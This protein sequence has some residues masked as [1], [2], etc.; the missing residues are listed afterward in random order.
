MKKA[1]RIVLKAILWIIGSVVGLILLVFILIR[2]PAIQNFVV[3]KVT[4]Y[5][6]N[7]IKTPVRI[8]R[9]TLDLP[10]MLVLEGVY[11][12]DQQRDTLLAGDKLK[13][14]ISMLKLLRN[15]VE[16]SEIDLQGITAKINRTLP[17]SA[18]NFDYIIRAFV[19]EDQA[20]DPAD[21]AAATMAFSIDK[22]NLDK[23]RLVYTDDVIGTGAVLNLGHLD[24]RI[25]T[26]DLENMRFDVPRINIS[27][28][29][30]EVKQWAVSTMAAA[31]SAEHFGTE[32][33]VGE[34]DGLPDLSFERFDLEDI[35]F[36]YIDETAAMN[37]RFSFKKLLAELNELDLNGEFVDIKRLE[38]EGSDSRILF[39]KAAQ[40]AAPDPTADTSAAEPMNWR[41]K[42]GSIRISETGFV[43]EDANQPRV[44]KGLDYGRLNF[45]NVDTELED[46]YYS[47]DS[48]SGSL[49]KLNGQ[50]HSGFAVRRLE[51]DFVYT[52]RGATLANLYV[53]T[54]H[55]RIRD[56][57]SVS[58]PSLD[59]ISTHPGEMTVEASIKKSHLGMRDVLM[60]MPDLDTMEVMKPLLQHTFHVDSRISG[61]VD[62]LR[63]PSL[64]FSTLDQTRLQ[65]SAHIR[66]LPD[67][68]R[69]R[70]DL[71]LK[72]FTTGRRDLERL[73]A[74]SMLPDS[75][76]LPENIRL[77]G[78]F[79]GGMNSFKTAMHLQSSIGVADVDAT[80]T[81]GR[82]TV[83]D[84][85]I[86]IADVN[87]GQLM[88]M[89]SVL[90]KISFAGHVKGRGL[91]PA[92]AQATVEARLISAEAMGYTYTDI[93]LEA[94]ANNGDISA[95]INS[96]DPNIKFNL[97]ALANMQGPYPRLNLSLMADTIHFKNLKLTTDDIRYHGKLEADLPTADP[98]HLNGTIN[99]VNS[100]VAYNDERFSLDTVSLRAES[101]DTI[102]RLVFQSEFLRAHM[103]G[104]YQ[105]TELPAAIQDVIATYYN[106]EPDTAT[107]QKAAYSPQ[108]FNFSA[109]FRRSR[110]IQRLVPELTE[111]QNVTL[112]GDFMS[113]EKSVNAKLVA[114]R[115]VYGGTIINEVSFDVNTYDSTLYYAALINRIAISNIEL[116]NTL[117]SGTIKN[118]L[119]QA[120]LWIRDKNDKEQYHI[121]ATV[122]ADAGN[123]VFSL[124][125]DGL[126][127]NYDKWDVN[128]GNAIAF[129]SRGILVNQFLLRNN[130]QELQLISQDSAYNSPLQV[131][132]N[133]FRIETF[134][135]IIESETLKIGGGIHGE[136]T[137]S[138]L[139]ADPVFVSD[140]TIREF[141]FGNRTVGDVGIRV[142]NERANTFAADISITGNGNDVRLTGDFIS[143]PEGSASFDFTLA[144][145]PLSMNTLEAFSLGYLRQTSGNIEGTLKITGTTD[146]PNINGA[147]NFNKASM[148]VAM[149]NATFN[150][151]QQRISFDNQGL[152][153]N[154][155]TLTDAAGN[156]A[157]LNGTVQTKSY[158]DFAFNLRFSTD[159]MQVINS[160]QKDN[161]MYYGK[162][163]LT[164][165]LNIRGDMNHPIVDGRIRVNDKTNLSFV[166]PDDNPGMVERE[167]IVQFVDKSDTLFRDVF[168][169]VDSLKQTQLSGMDLSVNLEID[170][171]AAF[172]IVIN[173]GTGDALF[174][175]GDAQLSA[176]LDP[177]GQIT[178][179]GVYEVEEGNYNF[180]FQ[181]IKK[182]F[183]FRKGSTIT[184]SGDP[185]AARLDI[186]AEYPIDAAPIDLVVNQL[187]DATRN[188]YKQRI[189]F[190]VNLI[191][192]GEM[193]KPQ[194]DFDIELDE[195][196]AN[197]S[198]D[199]TSTVSTK[200]T[201][202]RENPSEMNKQV[203][204]LIALGNFIAENPFASS[205]GG[206][207][208]E[209]LARGQLSSFL[210]NQL[211][212]LAGDLIAG[213]ELNF[214]LQSTEDYTTGQMQNRTDLNVG[215]SKRLLDDRLKVTIGSNFE[216]EGPTRPGAQTTNIAGDISVDYLL[217]SD[218]R[219][220]LRAYRKNQYQVTLQGQFVETG[221][222]FIINMDYDRFRE[223]FITAKQRQEREQQRQRRMRPRDG[224]ETDRNDNDRRERR[225]NQDE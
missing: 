4:G 161:D 41:V 144:L 3:Q 202:L 26:F 44:T 102:N 94:K 96:D 49:E 132:F 66:G 197:V 199:V 2:I 185:T 139:E 95:A 76:E 24:T 48:I 18:F 104:N 193:L 146:A 214:D 22:I 103:T 83:Y 74:K 25:R 89:D 77:H 196:N 149:L 217:S 81:A 110:L 50:D 156:K 51:T 169:K 208:F 106:P 206:G 71:N 167:G 207:G 14:D 137:V 42:A 36:A 176:G 91:D 180:S 221:L 212:R 151:D 100:A 23:I 92:K 162:L 140:L 15:R 35:V 98:D 168:G 64:T 27:G 170:R 184:W 72:E 69:L 195:D 65:A 88:K 17:D 111:M 130:G 52:D 117:L 12:E 209:S 122:K 93:D 187:D 112:D 54:P 78:T 194:L 155:F 63:I 68:E 179:T 205:A 133:N 79:N 126:I 148:N 58:Y 45:T 73:I 87:V 60:L 114:P 175:R 220:T 224:D 90:G 70:A 55:T 183:N 177:S 150:M 181:F 57:I 147:L 99:I 101:K 222:G 37:T 67:T 129:G 211:N 223:L 210:S 164:T 84:A 171:N 6:E 125:P 116:T 218:G 157:T 172:T 43:F 108:Q 215:V 34:S 61:R 119:V 160:T 33:A 20:P 189:P 152:R 142:N 136:A 154:R 166:I 107:V 153:F 163:F 186:T 135:R 123:F 203:F 39:G 182:R 198:Q 158:T 216:L 13:V 16:I 38:L 86:S 40:Q 141:F 29:R 5:L 105:L 56:H 80:Y 62:N 190:T 115:L 8:A 53:E 7:K 225:E 31:P 19:S 10:K 192:T 120:G 9:V 173:P 174:I 124:L 97:K 134:T 11:F 138:R 1:G 200:L 46:L 121:G 127:L 201:Q 204:A 109:E 118:S 213:V 113:A 30:A 159:N 178:M 145:N 75:L 21:T 82:D 59:R 47:A 165:N 131:S 85:Q 191:I 188:L 219:Y 128:E 28:V 32:A 143:P